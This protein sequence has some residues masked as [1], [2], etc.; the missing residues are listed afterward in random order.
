MIQEGAFYT[1]RIILEDFKATYEIVDFKEKIQ[2]LTEAPYNIKSTSH[3]AP[4]REIEASLAAKS[5]ITKFDNYL[6]NAFS[7]IKEKGIDKVWLRQFASSIKDAKEIK[8]NFTKAYITILEESDVNPILYFSAKKH[9]IISKIF[10][11]VLSK[12]DFEKIERNIDQ[13]NEELK[14][15]EWDDDDKNSFEI[16]LFVSLEQMIIPA[17]FSEVNRNDEQFIAKYSEL[18]EK[19]A[20]IIANRYP[21]EYL[22]ISELDKRFYSKDAYLSIIDNSTNL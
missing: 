10:F 8:H 20:Y 15:M 11:D 13:I 19:Y 17:A 3:K 22:R 1:G 5:Y 12:T 18:V 2:H 21:D 16:G 4:L 6:N 14:T 9:F 7:T